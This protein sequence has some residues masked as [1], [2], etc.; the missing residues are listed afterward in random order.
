[1]VSFVAV[2]ATG[3]GEVYGWRRGEAIAR[4]LLLWRQV[5]NAHACSGRALYLLTGAAASDPGRESR[6]FSSEV[7]TDVIVAWVGLWRLARVNTSRTSFFSNFASSSAG[8]QGGTMD[9]KL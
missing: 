4:S 5:Y 1:L 6:E 8:R 7:E 2:D 9:S 3:D